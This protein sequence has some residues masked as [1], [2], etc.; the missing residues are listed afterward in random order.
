[1]SNNK[2]MESFW[3]MHELRRAN[4]MFNGTYKSGLWEKSLVKED[5]QEELEDR[6]TAEAVED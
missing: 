5:A 3:E 2:E 1:M 4:A 6:E